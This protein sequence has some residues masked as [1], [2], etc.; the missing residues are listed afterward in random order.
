MTLPA[1]SSTPDGPAPV[2]WLPTAAAVLPQPPTLVNEHVGAA[3]PLADFRP[4]PPR[5]ACSHCASVRSGLRADCQE[6]SAASQPTVLA[7]KPAAPAADVT[8]S[9]VA[10]QMPASTQALYAARVPSVASISN[11]AS[12]TWC[13]GRSSALQSPSTASLQPIRN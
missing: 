7:G 8:K 12:V 1:M 13:D 5:S 3:V 10:G 6:A 2:G 4:S 11:A 9:A